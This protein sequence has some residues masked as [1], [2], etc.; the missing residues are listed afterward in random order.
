MKGILSNRFLRRTSGGVLFTAIALTLAGCG[1]S[2]DP[3]WLPVFPTSGKVQFKGAAPVGAYVAL[4]PKPGKAPATSQ[5]VV[6]RGQ[7]QP[8]GT[9]ALSSYTTSDGAPPGEYVAT[10]EW[11]KTVKNSSGEPILGPNLLPPQYSKPQTT[12]LKTIQ[13]AEGKN[14]LPEI[15][16]K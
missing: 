8:D 7:V 14:E 1:S 5:S 2:R 16:L 10:I 11:H 15:V 4:Y 13:I 9:F 6:P 12:P 3:N